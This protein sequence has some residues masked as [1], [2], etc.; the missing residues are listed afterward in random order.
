MFS[1]N[2]YMQ[3]SKRIQIENMLELLNRAHDSVKR[4]LETK[5]ND[6]ALELLE[7]CQD[8]A[9]QIGGMIEESIGENFI[10]VEFLE[11]YCELLYKAYESIRQ[12]QL[13]NSNKIYKN[14]R[15]ELIRIENSVKND[16]QVRL[17]AVFLPYKASMWDSLESVWK[18]ADEDPNCNTYVVPIPYFDKNPDGSFKEMHYDGNQ[19]PSYVP[20]T[21][22]EEFDIAAEHPD[23]IFIHNPYDE[24]NYVTSVHPAYY[25][26]EL[27][28]QT[29]CLVY[30]PYYILEEVDPNNKDAVEN[31]EHFCTVPAVVYA[32]K[33]IVQSKGWRRIYIDVMTKTMGA[34]TRHVWEK[35]ILG[36]GSPKLDKVHTTG[37]SD[38]DI[39]EEW[40]K[41]IVNPDGSW[42]KIIFY[43]T[44]VSALLQHGE[45]MLEKMQ[46]VFDVFKEN[47][48]EAALLWRP[49]PL[50]KATIESMRPQ[51]WMEYDKV[52]KAYIEEGWGIYDDTA[53]INRAIAVSD[54]Y[55]GDRSS[56]VKMYEETG[57]PVILQDVEIL[58]SEETEFI[59]KEIGFYNSVV[60]EDKLWFVSNRKELMK[61][62]VKT[63]ETAYVDWQDSE[64]EEKIA[65][66][67]DMFVY[68]MNLYWVDNCQRY[69]H[70]YDTN[71]N[72]YQCYP[73]PD[74]DGY[75]L[76]SDN[77]AGIYLYEGVLWLFLRDIPY[78]FEFALM[79]KNWKIHSE[80]CRKWDEKERETSKCFWRGSVQITNEI[81]L[82]EKDNILGKFNLNTCQYERVKIPDAI[83]EP[84]QIVW[85]NNALYILSCTG[86]V[87][88]WSEKEGNIEIIYG[89]INT[90]VPLGCMV[91]LER[92][93]FLAP[94]Q[95]EK[96]L[97]VD[98]E[99]GN[100]VY[101]AE[102]PEDL[103]YGDC[104]YGKY[105]N[106]T[107]DSEY[108][109]FDNRG[110][111]YI[112]RIN[113]KK[114]NIEWLKPQLP[115]IQDEW[116]YR[117]KRYSE[118]VMYEKTNRLERMM[119]M[120]RQEE[121]SQKVFRN[122][123]AI[124]WH[125]LMGEI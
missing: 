103:R 99:K 93:V 40:L 108:I 8:S 75:D 44:S 125:S 124:I 32:D 77:L 61:M 47:K 35:K 28:N 123:G 69:L 27:K 104:V 102:C 13:V 113:K 82:L 100:K 70:E 1:T 116:R 51:L 17:K 38:L 54:V 53:D 71:N 76:S 78:V 91:V 48:D 49:H 34:D 92:K 81:C 67:A 37:R 2:K 12:K 14:L 43:N 18:M 33:V 119:H 90:E 87:Y 45:K 19:Y 105:G 46:Y 52:V 96:I 50:I 118:F 65:V 42:K 106:F 114:E 68:S 79:Q 85:K 31:I 94:R 41:I 115:T 112:V 11:N 25:S 16:I 95:T 58:S 80:I 10:T 60:Y 9:I 30:I 57:K 59:E 3:K 22:W 24:F 110:G 121:Q 109:W 97:I 72:V 29:D 120:E 6:V 63:G 56:V 84:Q 5:N 39:P 117:K 101:Q 55:Y 86:K 15:K 7:Q 111:N 73:F 89:S 20:I 21:S 26:K 88:K 98:L 4:A 64:K 36:L 122:V 107:E 66:T 74:I 83:E 23:V 62:N